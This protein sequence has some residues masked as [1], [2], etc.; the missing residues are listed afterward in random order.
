MLEPPPQW[1]HFKFMLKGFIQNF[2]HKLHAKR[3]CKQD[4]LQGRRRLLLR[5]Q[6]IDHATDAL[7]HVESQLDQMYES[8]AS[9]LALRSGSRWREHGERLNSYFYRTIKS[10]RQK[11]A[12]H[13]LQ[14]SDGQ[15]VRSTQQLNDCA[16][17]FYEK[18]YSAEP[19]QTEAMEEIL[20]HIPPSNCFNEDVDNALTSSWT[21]EEI[22]AYVSKTPRNS[23]LGVDGIPYEI[24]QILLQHPFFRNLFAKILNIA[25]KESN[26][27][28]T[29]QQTVVVLLPKKGERSQ[30]KNWRP[31]SLIC[32]DAKIFTRL[33][34]TRVNEV[35]P[36]LIDIHQTGFMPERFIADNGATT[37]LIINIAER[38]KLPGIALLL[39]QEKAYDRVHPQYLKACLERFE[40][41]STLVTSILSLFFGTSLCINVN[42][43]L[44]TSIQQARGLRQGDPLSPLLFNLAIEPFLR[45]I[46][47]S[48]LISGFTFPRSTQSGLS[49][50]A[51]SS[52]PVK[53]LAYADDVLVFLK[54]P[55]ELQVLLQLVSLY[56]RASNA[57]LNH[58]KTLAVSLSGEEQLEW[59]TMLNANC[60]L[61]WHDNKDSTAAIYL[62]YP[63]TSSTQQMSNYL[64]SIITKV[65]RHADILAQRGLSIQGRSMVANSLLLSRIW[66]S[67]RI[68]CPPQSFFQRIRSVIIKFLRYKNFPSVKFQDCRRPR[69]EGGIAILGPAMQHSALQLRWL[70]PMLQ[71]THPAS[72]QESFATALMRYH[73]CV[74]TSSPSAIL[75][76]L[77]S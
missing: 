65:K 49:N 1:D 30:L 23:S 55:T 31:I 13:E 73:L 45:S 28:S 58:H 53:A 41:P 46:W 60:I 42:G 69:N 7:K 29:W 33:L 35:L 10:R 51:R 63:L 2:T 6:Y 18:L 68:L 5:Q 20:N 15:L 25:L 21:E 34:A 61:Q 54:G 59:R 4:Y 12:I 14:S 22:L 57:K 3:D 27:P 66:H 38:F 50:L 17:Q 40:F 32:A 37:R 48:S 72:T 26:F 77:F 47:S 52:P 9:T 44:T 39:D 75:P 11:Q 74:L 64:D 16:K 76:L 8:T 43:F 56:G 19:I 24:L 70:I 67:I 36:L 62:G 71:S